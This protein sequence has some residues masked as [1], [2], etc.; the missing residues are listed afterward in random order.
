MPEKTC[1]KIHVRNFPE[2]F[3]KISKG[4]FNSKFQS[5]SLIFFSS[6][7]GY[8]PAAAASLKENF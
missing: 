2:G 8:Q 5:Q 3:R 7:P 6:I 1:Q 4:I